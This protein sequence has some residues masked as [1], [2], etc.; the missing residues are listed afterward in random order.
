MMLECPQ[1]V[2][3]SM[4]KNMYN[5]QSKTRFNL[6]S[7]IATMF[8]DMQSKNKQKIEVRSRED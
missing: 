4:Y 2:L 1:H 3:T 5:L 7:S 6:L 8:V